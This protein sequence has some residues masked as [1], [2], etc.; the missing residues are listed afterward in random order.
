[1]P[2]MAG[3]DYLPI[4]CLPDRTRRSAWS[5]GAAPVSSTRICLHVAAVPAV[6]PRRH[7]PGHHARPGGPLLRIDVTATLRSNRGAPGDS[8]RVWNG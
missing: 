1:M 8:A 7:G 3:A 5:I 4:P 6:Q 2:A